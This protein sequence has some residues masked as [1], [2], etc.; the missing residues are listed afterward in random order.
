MAGR[1][2]LL[3]LTCQL[4]FAIDFAM[5]SAMDF[6]MDF[7]IDFAIDFALDLA[8][9]QMQAVDV[10]IISVLFIRRVSEITD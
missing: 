9:L 8:K 1:P 10:Y 4:T 7:A 3:L 5:D 6:A 2:W